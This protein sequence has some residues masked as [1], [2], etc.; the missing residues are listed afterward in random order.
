RA[1]QA[2]DALAQA[3]NVYAMRYLA[4]SVAALAARL[5]PAEAA[6]RASAAARQVVGAMV[7][8]PN[9]GVLYD[10]ADALAALAPLMAPAEAAAQTA[11]AADQIVDA[12]GKTNYPAHI[13]HLAAA[14]MLLAPRLPPG[15]AAR[16]ASAA[17]RLAL[18]AAAKTND[19]NS[20]YDLALALAALAPRLQPA[21][22]S[23]AGQ[24]ALDAM[25]RTNDNTYA[26]RELA[27][28][29]AAQATRL[30]PGE[31]ARQASVAARLAV[32]AMPSDNSGP[33]PLME[34]LTALVDREGPEETSQRVNSLA[35]A[36]GNAAA[37]SP[38][39]VVSLGPLEESSR[40]LPGRLTEQ[41]LVDLL[42]MPTC[43]KP[44]RQVI[45]RQ[46]GW[47]CGETFANQWEFVE[48]A[49]QHRPDLDLT[50][51]PVPPTNP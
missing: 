19:F 12:M 35:L 43:V 3:N 51:P 16:Q 2:M 47:Q 30:E 18:D 23:A 28:A 4:R 49:R 42:K 39:S 5:E 8:T 48:W 1:R 26:L 34:A 41:Q 21:E 38:A 33:K 44:A 9:P 46:L 7:K 29:V 25:A 37:V 6:R 20:L 45:V 11:F 50:S 31:A 27:Q 32:N 24:V 36:V 13:Q 17:A 14:L 10:M 15:E 22:A 40:P